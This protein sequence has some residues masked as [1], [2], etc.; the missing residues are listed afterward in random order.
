MRRFWQ[1]MIWG[2]MVGAALGLFMRPMTRP[3]KKP[4]AD[5]SADSLVSTTAGLMRQA[6][7]ARKRLVKK[8]S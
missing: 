3:S 7:R 2:G 8:M 5:Y 4:L 6:R 1:G